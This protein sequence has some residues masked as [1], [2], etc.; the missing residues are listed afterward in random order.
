MR[1]CARHR[2]RRVWACAERVPQRALRSARSVHVLTNR[3]PTPRDIRGGRQCVLAR[4]R[5]PSPGASRAGAG[6]GGDGGGDGLTPMTRPPAS[7]ALPGSSMTQLTV[8]PVALAAVPTTDDSVERTAPTGPRRSGGRSACASAAAASGSALG[9]GVAALGAGR[10]ACADGGTATWLGGA[11]TTGGGSVGT[12][13]RLPGAALATTGAVCV[14]GWAV[15]V[16]GWLVGDA[17]GKPGG[18][19][20]T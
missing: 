10:A 2:A 18:G 6:G 11:T 15:C 17:R 19:A 9:P 5:Q 1:P 7:I 16:G 20:G 3:R 8:C 13:G 12:G 4:R 14:G